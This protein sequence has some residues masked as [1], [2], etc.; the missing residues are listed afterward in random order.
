MK[1]CDYCGE[2]FEPKTSRQRFCHAPKKCQR[3][4]WK[5]HPEKRKQYTFV[6]W[7]CGEKYQTHDKNRNKYCSREHAFED[8]KSKPKV[9]IENK[10]LFCGEAIHSSSKHYHDKCLIIK[11]RQRSRSF[12][13]SKKEIKNRIC[14]GCGILFEAE[15]GNKHNKFHSHECGRK[16]QRRVSKA[17]RR[18][19]EKNLPYEF[20]DP[21]VVFEKDNWHCY[22]CHCSTPKELRGSLADNAPELDHVIPLSL[23][24]HHVYKNVR[25]ICRKHNQE[26]GGYALPI[27]AAYNIATGGQSRSHDREIGVGGVDGG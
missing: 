7:H 15:Y 12:S 4:Y 18:A 14:K 19:R 1:T 6:C 3:N 25:C 5:E 23:G 22:I 9:R 13:A 17:Q 26:K 27:F 24:G 16:Y 21:F 2:Q 8:K 10:C 20:I 11:E